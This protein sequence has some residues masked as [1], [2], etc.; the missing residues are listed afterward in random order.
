[1]RIKK[2]E[3]GGKKMSQTLWTQTTPC[4]TSRI[5]RVMCTYL[6]HDVKECGV[7]GCVASWM[8][9]RG[10]LVGSNQVSPLSTSRIW[11][12]RTWTSLYEITW[13]LGVEC[14]GIPQCCKTEF[15][16]QTVENCGKRVPFGF[17]NWIKFQESFSVFVPVRSRSGTN[18][19]FSVF[20]R[21]DGSTKWLVPPNS[22]SPFYY[23]KFE[24]VVKTR[25]SLNVENPQKSC[26]KVI[27][28]HRRIPSHNTV[29]LLSLRW[30]RVVT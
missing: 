11:R 9:F 1:M 13:E 7:A 21:I 8:T 28:T 16:Q 24:D 14:L 12:W 23:T 27:Y 18:H 26:F 2:R 22:N 19:T 5:F 30:N 17:R 6:R 10:S 25:W 20:V 15:V 29:C 3:G 4:L